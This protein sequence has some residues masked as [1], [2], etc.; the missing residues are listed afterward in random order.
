MRVEDYDSNLKLETSISEPG[1]TWFDVRKAPF[2]IY[3]LYQP[4]DASRPFHRLPEEVAAATNEGV[5]KLNFHTAGGRVRFSTDSPYI[6]I[7]CEMSGSL[8]TTI[9][10]HMALSGSQGF[11]LWTEQG[12]GGA[13]DYFCSFM[14][15][16]DFSATTYESV[17]SAM[18]SGVH[19]YTLNFPLYG[20]CKNLYIGVKEG[21]VLSEGKPY[22]DVAPMVYYGSS[23]T[24]GGCASRPGSAYENYICAKY[25]IDYVNMGFSGSARGEKPMV[26]YLASMNMSMFICDYDHNAPT[27]EHLQATLEPLYRAIR[28]KHPRIP[29]I[30]MSSPGMGLGAPRRDFIRSIWEKACAEGDQNVYFVDGETMF[31]GEFS[32]A[33]TVDRCHP[34]DLGFFRMY[35]A[36]DQ[37]ISKLV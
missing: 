7:K 22:R 18:P 8:Y 17:F 26:D 2:Q 34:T 1:L 15:S 37:V 5:K 36:L 16:C 20:I 30:F 25:N 32:H 9:M 10:R 35:Q 12:E 14:P 24:Q 28:A 19:S 13:E 4:L 31:A 33:Y 21:S 27:L 23:I 3:G 11:D 6:A 29:Y